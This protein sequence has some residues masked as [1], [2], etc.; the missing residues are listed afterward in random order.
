MANPT[1]NFGWVMPTSTDLVTDL[2]ADFAVFGQ[3]V[4]TTMADLKGGTTGQILSKA[5][6][7]DMDFTW[8]APVTGDITA[9]TAGTG[10]SGGGTSGDVTITNSM[11]TTITTAGDT[12]YGT[13]SAAVARLGIGSS[14]QVLTVASGVPSWATPSSGALVLINTTSFTSSSAVNINNVFSTTYQYYKIVI[15]VTSVSVATSIFQRMRVGGADTTTGYLSRFMN[16]NSTTIAGQNQTAGFYLGETNTTGITWF[17]HSQEI[18]NAFET[19]PTQMIGAGTESDGGTLKQTKTGG[20]LDNSTSYTGTT[21][22][23]VSGNMT[24]TV[25]IYAYVNS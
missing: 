11:Q 4:D 3:G 15:N 6:N 5:T 12:L 10:I 18:L 23:T 2:P 21:F 1:T 13:G 8:V 14:G 7:T 17:S 24:G 25:R 20:V 9:V 22:Y 16:Q 19:R